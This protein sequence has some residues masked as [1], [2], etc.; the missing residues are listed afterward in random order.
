MIIV[1]T[2]EGKADHAARRAAA[3]KIVR[4]ELGCG[5]VRDS[6]GAPRA[7]NGK[8]H[9]SIS[10]T[11]RFIA[12]AFSRKSIGVDIELHHREVDHLAARFATKDEIVI[13]REVFPD[14]P[15]LLVWCAKEAIYKTLHREGIDFLKD[16][17][18]TS[19]TPDQLTAIADDLVVELKWERG[20]NILTACTI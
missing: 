7:E 4:T 13:C 8:A 15:T 5:I 20:D 11:D 2:I 18:I 14:N 6:T 3:D 1:E 10:H 16:M 17:T 9:I 19:A 12:V